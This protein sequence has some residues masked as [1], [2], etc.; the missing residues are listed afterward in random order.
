MR[1]QLTERNAQQ[2][3]NVFLCR[4]RSVMFQASPTEKRQLLNISTLLYCTPFCQKP[5]DQ[6]Q[7]DVAHQGDEEGLHD[8]YQEGLGSNFRETAW[9]KPSEGTGEAR[10]PVL[11]QQ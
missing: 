3:N 1:K 10:T 5:N 11:V 9:K 2:H 7:V 4:R 6:L 8:V